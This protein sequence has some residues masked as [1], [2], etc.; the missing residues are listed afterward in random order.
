MKKLIMCVA[1]FTSIVSV[2]AQNKKGNHL[3]GVNVGSGSFSSSKY[4]YIYSNTTTTYNGDSKSFNIGIGP[5]IGW[6][7]TDRLVVGTYLSLYYYHSNSNS[8]NSSTAVTSNSNSNSLYFTLGPSAR[9]YLGKNNGKG[10]PYVS[11]LTGLSFYPSDNGEASNSTN[12]YHYT[13]KTKNYFS[14]NIGPRFGYEHFFNQSLGLHYYIGYNYNKYK[15]KYDYDYSVGGTDYSYTYN[16]HSHNV[17]FG[18]GLQ[19]HL[20]CEKKKK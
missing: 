9:L 17:T 6:Y 19:M 14:W 16:S 11:L 10:M 15:Y 12:T 3:V 13:Y 5:E 4:D 1:A 7:L 18:V 20:D 8:G 2:Q